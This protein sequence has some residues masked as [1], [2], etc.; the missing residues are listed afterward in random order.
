MQEKEEQE[1]MY[2]EEEKQLAEEA[3][4]QVRKKRGERDREKG[5]TKRRLGEGQ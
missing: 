1:E 5:M 4:V 2:K 3:F